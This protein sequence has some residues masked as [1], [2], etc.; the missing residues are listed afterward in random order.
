MQFCGA[1]LQW[2][3]LKLLLVVV[4]LAGTREVKAWLRIMNI[5][6]FSYK[7]RFFSGRPNTTTHIPFLVSA[8]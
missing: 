3:P 8:T 6:T 7:E 2:F 5:L 4:S 1:M